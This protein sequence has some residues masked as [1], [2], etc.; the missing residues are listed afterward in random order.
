MCGGQIYVIA[1]PLTTVLTLQASV[2]SLGVLFD[3]L[4]APFLGLPLL[5]GVLIGRTGLRR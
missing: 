3:C 1:L 5:M 2:S 4:F